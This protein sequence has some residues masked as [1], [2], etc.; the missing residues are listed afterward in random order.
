MLAALMGVLLLLSSWLQQQ[1]GSAGVMV[2]A[3]AVA[4]V[5]VH[6]A[7]AALAQLAAAGQMD[8]EAGSWGVL[9]LLTINSL[10][11]S[12]IAFVSGGARYGWQVTLGLV[13]ASALAGLALLLFK[14]I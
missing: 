13:S 10:A 4:L 3:G 12:G 8:S 2:A 9:L 1:F 14:Y 5:E 6:A 7:G 11:K